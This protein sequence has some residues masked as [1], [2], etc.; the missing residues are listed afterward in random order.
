MTD[1]QPE[2]LTLDRMETPIGQALLVTDTDGVLCA[3]DWGDHETRLRRLLSRYYGARVLLLDGA[4][5]RG[6]RAA[7]TAYF[8]GDLGALDAIPCRRT[9]SAFQQSAWDALRK[10]PV[11]QTVSYGEQARR[12]GKPK[13][14]RAVGLANGANPIGLVIPCHR[15]IGA[16]GSLTGYGGGLERKLWLLRHEGAMV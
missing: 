6:I 15:V 12:M 16:N 11:G 7:L 10:I 5:P 4:A 9:G 2:T 8:D 14:V 3:F 13:A 1:A